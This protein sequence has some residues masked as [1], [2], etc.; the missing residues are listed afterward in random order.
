MNNF[1]YLTNKENFT[2]PNREDAIS[3]FLDQKAFILSVNPGFDL[4]K[5]YEEKGASFRYEMRP[6][7]G[8][9]P[10]DQWVC[11]L[12]DF[13]LSCLKDSYPKK[14]KEINTFFNFF[15]GKK[16][17][18]EMRKDTEGNIIENSF[19]FNSLSE[20]MMSGAY[21]QLNSVISHGRIFLLDEFLYAF[22]L[23]YSEIKDF[24]DSMISKSD[25]ID[26][27]DETMFASNNY[28]KR[29][30]YIP[31]FDCPNLSEEERRKKI[32]A[33]IAADLKRVL[34]VDMLALPETY[35]KEDIF[36]G[37]LFNS[38]LDI[39]FDSSA[40][41]YPYEMK[42]SQLDEYLKNN[43]DTLFRETT[44]SGI[45]KEE[46]SFIFNNRQSINSQAVY[47]IALPYDLSEGSYVRKGNPVSILDE[48]HDYIDKEYKK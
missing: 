25:L 35:L 2:I 17:Q 38:E 44:L 9:Q 45:R 46:N 28:E 24:A 41:L 40:L 18:E 20:D 7:L 22:R 13:Y 36:E 1:S 48:Y 3:A 10:S 19:S 23:S 16:A 27:L 32:Q 42:G 8:R 4:K 30:Y 21:E 34:S 31:E 12:P 33:K 26:N 43:Y 47:L 5:A 29:S 15:S 37:L 11:S 6:F 39:V 14:K